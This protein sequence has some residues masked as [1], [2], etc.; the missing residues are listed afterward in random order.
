MTGVAP[1]PDRN[2]HRPRLQHRQPA[3][4]A[5]VPPRRQPV[6]PIR[7]QPSRRTAQRRPSGAEL[8]PILDGRRADVPERGNAECDGRNPFALGVL[9]DPTRTYDLATGGEQQRGLR[10]S[11][12]GCTHPEIRAGAI[13]RLRKPWRQ[14]QRTDRRPRTSHGHRLLRDP[15]KRS[16]GQ[17]DGW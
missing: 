7:T 15:A 8:S 11:T 13:R 4:P 6:G 9:L 17:P 14:R 3:A 1:R 5:T 2:E 16:R 12:R 10:G